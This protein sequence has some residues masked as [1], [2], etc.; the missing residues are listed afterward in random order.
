VST[1]KNLLLRLK[2]SFNSAYRSTITLKKTT[3]I[4]LLK[5]CSTSIV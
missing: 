3:P 1:I 4:Q 2:D 5:D